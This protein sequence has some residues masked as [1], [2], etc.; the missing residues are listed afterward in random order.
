MITR[1]ITEWHAARVRRDRA[2]EAACRRLNALG[3]SVTTRHPLARAAAGFHGPARQ[4]AALAEIET[5][6]YY[7]KE[8]TR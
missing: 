5:F 1:R 8:L 6:E 4:A 2:A 7:E 3:W